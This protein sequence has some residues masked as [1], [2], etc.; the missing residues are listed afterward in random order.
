[1]AALAS[2][3]ASVNFCFSS[4]VKSS[5][6]PST[7]LI[8][9][10]IALAAVFWA[11]ANMFLTIGRRLVSV[12]DNARDRGLYS[13]KLASGYSAIEDPFNSSLVGIVMVNLYSLVISS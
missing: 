8:L 5:S 12:G 10:W 6:A 9:S 11:R 1:M 4:A 13:T 2:L 3:R 7:S